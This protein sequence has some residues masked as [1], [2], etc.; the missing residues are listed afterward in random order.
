MITERDQYQQYLKFITE[1]ENKQPV[2]ISSFMRKELRALGVY[3]YEGKEYKYLKLNEIEFNELAAK[4]KNKKVV[5]VFDKNNELLYCSHNLSLIIKRFGNSYEAIKFRCK[6][7]NLKQ[8][9]YYYSY[10]PNFKIKGDISKRTVTDKMKKHCAI[11]KGNNVKNA[12]LRAWAIFNDLKENEDVLKKTLAEIAVHYDITIATL[13]NYKCRYDFLGDLFK[14]RNTL[15]VKQS[16]IKRSSSNLYRAYLSILENHT[17]ENFAFDDMGVINETL[18]LFRDMDI[19]S[20]ENGKY[21]FIE[22]SEFDFIKKLAEIKKLKV[23]YIFNTDNEIVNLALGKKDAERRTGKSEMTIRCLLAN[24]SKYSTDYYFSYDQK[25]KIIATKK[26][27]KNYERLHLIKVAEGLSLA[28][29]INKLLEQ[30]PEYWH[31]SKQ[32]ISEKLEIN[33]NTLLRYITRYDFL[34]KWNDIFKDA[35]SKWL[36]ETR[37]QREKDR[38]FRLKEEK[39]QR[40]NEKRVSE[41]LKAR[42]KANA[43]KKKKEKKTSPE[44]RNT[45]TNIKRLG[46]LGSEGL[47]DKLEYLRKDKY[48]SKNRNEY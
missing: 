26:V 6:N 41:I 39:I 27:R 19:C 18:R 16:N 14:Y 9:D 32:K 11:N 31:L 4:K 3:S 38:I 46:K 30:H 25:F 40:E 13:N 42:A 2:T 29:K 23:I 33:I 43:S 47:R 48:L 12:E 34:N 1:I 28:E 10:N 8:K 5:Y 20:K 17:K 36:I 21:K 22:I 45:N 44:P 15:D 7:D 37:A 24:P 35:K